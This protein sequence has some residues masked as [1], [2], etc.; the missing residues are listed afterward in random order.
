MF[1][2]LQHIFFTAFLLLSQHPFMSSTLGDLKWLYLT[3][4]VKVI[5]RWA[6][7]T[8]WRKLFGH[9][10]LTGNFNQLFLN[11]TFTNLRFK[12]ITRKDQVLIF[13]LRRNAFQYP[14]SFSL[15][16]FSLFL[17]R[18]QIII[19]LTVS[20]PMQCYSWLERQLD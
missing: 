7:W 19:F 20:A 16:F 2:K 14:Y 5:K 8:I 3:L 15:H 18:G 10:L 17:K 11:L 4:Q 1:E 12:I 13:L 9:S 6:Q